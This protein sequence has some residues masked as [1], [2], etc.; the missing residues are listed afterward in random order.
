MPI[1]RRSFPTFSLT[2]TTSVTLVRKSKGEYVD[3]NWV[4]GVETE[5]PIEANVQPVQFKE[6]MQFPE[7]DRT[8]EWIKLYSVEQIRTANEAPDGW[9]ADEVVWDGYRYKVMKSRHY[10]MGVLDH[11]HALAAREPVS[12]GGL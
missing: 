2:N 5:V 9:E 6:L 12:A 10:V 11:Y 1:T 3:G 4:E 8:K 7:S